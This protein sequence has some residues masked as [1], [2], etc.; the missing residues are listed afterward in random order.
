MK[1]GINAG[2][3][4]WNVYNEKARA[5]LERY[6]VDVSS[7][8]RDRTPSVEEVQGMIR[9]AEVV[10]GTW[11]TLPFTGE[12]LS[13][14]PELKLVVY[15]AGSVKGFTTPQL[16]ERGVTVLSAAHLNAI[17]V[18][19]YVLGVILVSLKGLH[20]LSS[21]IRA[22][23]AAEFTRDEGAAPGCYNTTVGLLGFGKVSRHLI[24]LLAH[25]DVQVLVEDPYLSQEQAMNL[26][27]RKV[28]KMELISNSDVIS[29]HHADV[30][31]NWNMIDSEALSAMRPGATFI[32][33]S[34]GR[35]VDEDAL[36]RALETSDLV[37]Y[38]DVTHPEPPQAGHPFYELPNCILTPHVAGSYAREVERMGSWAVDQ[39]E[40]YLNGEPL[41]GTVDLSTLDSI[42]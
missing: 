39:L 19:E 28:S 22:H 42:A 23:G 18:A 15:A 34:R 7:I 24:S 11:G 37:A 26:G 5:R 4:F 20:R 13:V 31:G 25:F 32:N 33:T 27:V 16:I 40:H 30:P 29:L 38:L 2:E 9:G 1:V 6:Q 14:A 8:P 3:Q 12:L 21:R 36:V 10:L 35:L 17:P 41:D